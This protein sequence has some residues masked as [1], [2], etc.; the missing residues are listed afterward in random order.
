MDFPAYF[1][2]GC[3]PSDAQEKEL[4]AYRLCKS[5]PVVISDF[6]SYYQLRLDFNGVNGYGVS[7]FTDLNEAITLK[8]MPAHKNEM[9]AKGVTSH[10]CGLMKETPTRR[11]SSHIT[12]WL[13]EDARPENYFQVME[14]ENNG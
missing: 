3:P 13:Y 11:F 7:L 5:N 9:L 4:I 8:K 2:Q 1:P 12:W 14:E 6:Y 10:L